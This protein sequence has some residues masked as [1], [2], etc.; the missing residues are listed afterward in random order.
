MGAF[1]SDHPIIAAVLT[2]FLA[3]YAFTAYKVHVLG[4]I[5]TKDKKK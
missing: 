1:F 5:A 2:L 3:D 4:R